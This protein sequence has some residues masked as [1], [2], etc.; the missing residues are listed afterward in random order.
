MDK[1]Y[2]K[3][4]LCI[5]FLSVLL[6]VPQSVNAKSGKEINI[7]KTFA[8]G[9]GEEIRRKK[10]DRNQDGYLNQTEI[11]KIKKLHLYTYQNDNINSNLNIKGISKL[12]YLERIDFIAKGDIYNLKE[13]KKLS[14]LKYVKIERN[15]K[16][17]RVFDFRKSKN[18]KTLDL[19]MKFNTGIVKVC[20]KNRI[21][22]LSIG[23]V[24]NGALI[25]DR[26]CK[27][28]KLEIVGNNDSTSL[29]LINNKKLVEL[30]LYDVKK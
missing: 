23:G 17:K 2:I 19:S 8:K 26:C 1:K 21:T 10:Y 6:I 27:A 18:L 15:S 14:N 7:K 11:K 4:M 22:T 20:K 12:K 29:N 16:K 13:I 3:V 30:Y 5:M 9:T 28:R 24:K 25:A